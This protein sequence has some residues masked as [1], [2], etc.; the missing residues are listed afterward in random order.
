MART[1][2]V[3]N[4]PWTTKADDLKEAFE[5]Y[6]EVISSRVITDRETGRSRGFGFVEVNDEDADK[7]IEALNGAELEGRVITV[8]EAKAR[9]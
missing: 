7:M 1:L 9:E 8:N 6:G 4:L 2:Y 5:A 3:G